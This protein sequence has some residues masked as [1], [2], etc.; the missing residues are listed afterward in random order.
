MFGEFHSEKKG[1]LVPGQQPRTNSC[2]KKLLGFEATKTSASQS[3]QTRLSAAS[4]ATTMA[5]ISPATGSVAPITAREFKKRSIK[6]AEPEPVITA[7]LG[8]IF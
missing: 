4:G 1:P 8:L 3:R 6:H 7:R 2:I 5:G